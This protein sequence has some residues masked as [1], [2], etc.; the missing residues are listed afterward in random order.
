MRRSQMVLI[1]VATIALPISACSAGQFHGFSSLRYYGD[2]DRR[3]QH[4]QS[5]N[6]SHDSGGPLRAQ[7]MPPGPNNGLSDAD[8]EQNE[9]NI[10][11]GVVDSSTDSC[12]GGCEVPA[13][14]DEIESATGK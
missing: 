7:G 3:S 13:N 6:A 11:N 8:Y 5:V 12:A 9:A 1:V 2:G 4:R 14:I 10:R